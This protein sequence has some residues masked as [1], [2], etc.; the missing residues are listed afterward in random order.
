MCYVVSIFFRDLLSIKCERRPILMFTVG[1]QAFFRRGLNQA[2]LEHQMHGKVHP[3][4]RLI[5]FVKVENFTHQSK[6]F[7][8]WC[9]QVRPNTY[10]VSVTYLKMSFVFCWCLQSHPYPKIPHTS[11]LWVIRSSLRCRS[12]MTCFRIFPVVQR[13][14]SLHFQYSIPGVVD[15]GVDRDAPQQQCHI[16]GHSL[17]S[18]LWWDLVQ[19]SDCSGPLACYKSTGQ[20]GGKHN[21]FPVSSQQMKLLF[22]FLAVI[23]VV[24][25]RVRFSISPDGCKFLR[26]VSL[27]SLTLH[28][29]KSTSE[30]GPVVNVPPSFLTR[31]TFSF[32]LRFTRVYT[33]GYA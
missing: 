8:W 13:P 33:I 32:H 29:V 18:A 4:T 15:E 14:Q 12:S 19:S 6:P 3:A 25:A 26:T 2:L 22:A 31:P 17:Q 16:C 11:I 24:M 21:H 30:V 9:T 5:C 1:R 23:I 7:P 20:D 28:V 10:L 27:H